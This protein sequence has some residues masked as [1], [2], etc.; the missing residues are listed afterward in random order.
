M[1]APQASASLGGATASGGVVLIDLTESI[2]RAARDGSVVEWP[3]AVGYLDAHST[4][5]NQIVAGEPIARS[6]SA[7][8]L[9]GVRLLPTLVDVSHILLNNR[10]HA[11]VDLLTRLLA[12][13]L[14]AKVVHDDPEI[15]VGH[16]SVWGRPRTEILRSCAERL[17]TRCSLLPRSVALARSL[18]GP[19]GRVVAVIEAQASSVDISLLRSQG[20]T[21]TQLESRRLSAQMGISLTEMGTEV[22][23]ELSDI[24]QE[25]TG[26]SDCSRALEGL[27][28][29]APPRLAEAIVAQIQEND[30]AFDRVVVAPRDAVLHGLAMTVPAPAAEEPTQQP[31]T[32]VAAA[33]PVAPISLTRPQTPPTTASGTIPRGPIPS[34]APLPSAPSGPPPHQQFAPSSQS[35][36]P[37]YG[38]APYIPQQPPAAERQNSEPG[39]PLAKPLPPREQNSSTDNLQVGSATRDFAF[40]EPPRAVRPAVWIGAAAALVVVLIIGAVAWFSIGS[41]GGPLQ[42]AQSG[43]SQ[44]PAEAGKTI[45]PSAGTT[46]LPARTDTR[47]GTEQ[48]DVP[49]PGS[50]GAVLFSF[51]LP[52]GW[53]Q[54]KAS[55]CS[56]P[57]QGSAEGHA[58]RS[59]PLFFHSSDD[60]CT[61]IAVSYEGVDPQ[62]TLQSVGE[63]LQSQMGQSSGKFTNLRFG[64]A[65]GQNFFNSY[66][67]PERNASWF[68]Y[69]ATHKD[70]KLLVSIGCRNNARGADCETALQTLAVKP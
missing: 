49:D 55:A 70:S 14:P 34:P 54:T 28:T 69:V 65:H 17:G 66:D 3:T 57:K 40:P 29:D 19:S 26:K 62:A 21:W 56:P 36:Q 27:I 41:D 46:A 52:A 5:P 37:Q 43:Q 61:E 58:F 20:G 18:A 51:Q 11:V 48:V 42:Q 33:L 67:Q 38:R 13:A 32:H 1:N 68:L 53:A 44:N 30:P 47:G 64:E 35:M 16:P 60:P 31:A 39:L 23:R 45:T 12:P 63:S 4:D 15:L 9:T 8:P 24:L 6:L 7:N 10:P 50:T 25:K 59:A 22:A 2:V